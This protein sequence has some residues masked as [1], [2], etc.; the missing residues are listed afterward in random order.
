MFTQS[1]S[2]WANVTQA[3]ILTASD[4]AVY[5][6]LGTSVSISGNTVV[7]GSPYLTVVYLFA[8][9]VSGWAEHGADRH[10]R[11]IFR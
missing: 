4:A 5:D 8:E 2:G 6:G 10:A 11:H 7:V 1:E 3:A 9:P